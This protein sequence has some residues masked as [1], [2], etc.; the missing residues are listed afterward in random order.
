MPVDRILLDTT[1]RFLKTVLVHDSIRISYSDL[2]TLALRLA[3]ALQ[4][5]G[6]RRGDR[7]MIA[8]ENLGYLVSWFGVILSGE[9]P[10]AINPDIKPQVFKI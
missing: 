4:N 7:I 1:G 2:C 5:Y 3:S 9:V 10:V 6:V 8:L